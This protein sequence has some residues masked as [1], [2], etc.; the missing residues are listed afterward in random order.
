MERMAM[1]I[2]GFP[3]VDK[4]VEFFKITGKHSEMLDFGAT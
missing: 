4:L 2:G 1:K 3:S